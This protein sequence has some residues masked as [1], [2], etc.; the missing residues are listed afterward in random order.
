MPRIGSFHFFSMNQDHPF[1]EQLFL[2]QTER[3]AAE[4]SVDPA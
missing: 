2:F 3:P 4:G 1:P